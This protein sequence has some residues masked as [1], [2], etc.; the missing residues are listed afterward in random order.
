MTQGKGRSKEQVECGHAW[1]EASIS[2][3]LGVSLLVVRALHRGGVSGKE[4]R[5][6]MARWT[7][8]GLVPKV[9]PV[10]MRKQDFRSGEVFVLVSLMPN[11]SSNR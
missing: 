3:C 4:C 7:L 10:R 5:V 1:L 6:R 2:V 8:V 9:L 11:C